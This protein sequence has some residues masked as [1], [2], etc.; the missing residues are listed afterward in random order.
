MAWHWRQ[1]AEEQWPPRK[2]TRVVRGGG[3]LHA[4]GF[5][6]FYFS[7]QFQEVFSDVGRQSIPQ[8]RVIWRPLPAVDSV[9]V[10]L[11]TASFPQQ[12]LPAPIFSLSD[13]PVGPEYRCSNPLVSECWT[14]TNYRKWRGRRKYSLG[15]N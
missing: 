6:T 10:V 2:G 14:I 11:T 12:W 3:C 8:I 9:V 15:D 5:F 7:L 4:S 13:F 1:R